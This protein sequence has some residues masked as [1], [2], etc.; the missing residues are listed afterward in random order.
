MR[1]PWSGQVTTPST[2]GTVVGSAAR[3]GHVRPA[4]A[5]RNAPIAGL[6]CSESS[7]HSSVS[8]RW[9]LRRRHLTA[10]SGF[11]KRF[12]P[13]VSA[14]GQR[15]REARHVAGAPPRGGE[16]EV[17]VVVAMCEVEVI[18]V[19][20]QRRQHRPPSRLGAPP[21]ARSR[22]VSSDSCFGS[23]PR[24]ALVQPH[25]VGVGLGGTAAGGCVAHSAQI[26][27]ASL[28]QPSRTRAPHSHWQRRLSQRRMS[29]FPSPWRKPECQ[30]PRNPL[31]GSPDTT[32][33]PEPRGSPAR[34][35]PVSMRS[36]GHP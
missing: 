29:S 25:R 28:E 13:Y 1:R 3:C 9:R 5:P 33:T 8:T 12:A 36:F 26:F 15:R 23:F 34:Y 21:R 7:R 6:A 27:R 24:R 4:I 17:D 20:V 14:S 32:S 30:V 2:I 11:G 35:S 18:G 10:L 31:G 16:P 22:S 19:G